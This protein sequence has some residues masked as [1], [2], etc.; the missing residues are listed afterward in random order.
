MLKIALA[1][2]IYYDN[3]MFDPVADKPSKAKTSDLI[4]ELGQVE[5]IF[6]DKTGTLT[7]NVMEFRKC[8]IYNQIYGGEEDPTRTE[9]DFS[10]NG[11]TSAAKILKTLGTDRKIERHAITNFFRL[12]SLC[13]SAICE[14]NSEKGEKYSVFINCYKIFYSLLVQMR[15][16][17]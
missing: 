9:N 13:H 5:F 14:S 7:Q 10:I 4:E 2:M 8:A 6:S 17:F 11:D 3:D 16:L 1:Q 15:W 12:M